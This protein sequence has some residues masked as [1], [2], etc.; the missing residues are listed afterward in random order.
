MAK[1]PL[2]PANGAALSREE[3]LALIRR[4]QEWGRRARV[5]GAPQ[6]LGVDLIRED[7]DFG[8]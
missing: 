1:L 5:K 6:S 4:S 7:R 8:H 2:R 3:K